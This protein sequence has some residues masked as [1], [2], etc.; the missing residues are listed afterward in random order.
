[1]LADRPWCWGAVALREARI[2]VVGDSSRLWDRSPF[3]ADHTHNC[4]SRVPPF[5][6]L[7]SAA[8][9]V[10]RGSHLG[11]TVRWRDTNYWT[12]SCHHYFGAWLIP[13]ALLTCT[14]KG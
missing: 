7:H 10:R 1:M 5:H 3:R 8:A 14:A 12:R 2:G 4:H 6:I 11:T 9:S 13:A